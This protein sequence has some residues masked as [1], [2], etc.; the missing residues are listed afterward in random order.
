NYFMQSSRDR[1]LVME[2]LEY[3]S[4]NRV[5]YAMNQVGGVRRD[6]DEDRV[7]AAHK[8]IDEL[9]KRTGDISKVLLNDVSIKLR[10]Q[11]IAKLSKEDAIALG[12]VGPVARASG[13]AYDVRNTGYLIYPELNFKP[14]W[15]TAG[16]N[17]ARMQVRIREL[18]ESYRMVRE[19]LKLLEAEGSGEIMLS[20][21]PNQR[22][23]GQA[24]VRTEAPRGEAF[25]YVKA[26]G[27][28]ELER[29]RVR[30]PTYANIYALTKML[31]GADL[32]DLPV[33]VVTIDPCLSCTDR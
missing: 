28:P 20:I 1:E 10:T 9:E 19:A 30:T 2:L 12:T 11:G 8:A 33:A 4:G 18:F 27:T 17:Y 21:K 3:I 6:L 7:K 16:D 32:A 26:N 15:E 29:V 14:V 22:P 13:V 23:N 25:H 31:P 24:F 5:N